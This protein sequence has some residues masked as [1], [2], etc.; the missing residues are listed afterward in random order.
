[1]NSRTSSR[2]LTL[3]FCII[4][5]IFPLF[6][7]NYY[8]N[9]Q[10]SKSLFFIALTCIAFLCMLLCLPRRTFSGENL[11]QYFRQ[12]P[13]L[14]ATLT[15]LLASLYSSI[16]S[17]YGRAAFTG[18]NGRYIGFFLLLSMFISFLLFA[19]HSVD[20]RPYHIFLYVG[21]SLTALIGILQFV[22]ID[23][24][25]LS[26]HVPDL[27]SGMY[28][29]TIGQ[30]NTFSGYASMFSAFCLGAYCLTGKKLLLFPLLVGYTA[31]FVGNS[32]NGFLCLLAVIL[33]L[34]LILNDK[35]P[36]FR[37][38]H[39]LLMLGLSCVL[40]YIIETYG[41]IPYQG[42][43]AVLSRPVIFIPLLLATFLL[44]FIAKTVLTDKNRFIFF[45]RIYLRILVG[46]AVSLLVLV[47]LTNLEA[48]HIFPLLLDDNWGS[49]RGFIW[50]K[51]IE[52]Y[53]DAPL[54]NK[55]FGYGPDTLKPLLLSICK[56]EMLSV[57]GKIYD[58]AHNDFL[59]YLI[60]TG[61]FGA[62]SWLVFWLSVL[63]RSVKTAAR[64]TEIL[65]WLAALIAYLVQTMLIPTQPITA[66]LG[67]MIAGICVGLTHSSSKKI[68]QETAS[69]M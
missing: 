6:F 57:T 66:P 38:L 24:L 37:L 45:K 12:T 65:P 8:Y 56:D 11:Y 33:F 25:G 2:I 62:L 39:G 19:T 51:V 41:L 35:K 69:P 53:K 32:D 60:T 7:T 23:F 40:G 21:G 68:P 30:I 46:L 3:Y 49:F 52:V 1:M 59:Q 14:W 16:F 22:R 5:C 20:L 34:P 63:I 47:L 64:D 26:S 42:I 67:F 50:R 36:I 10:F 13:E 55:L 43:P 44:Y 17:A 54:I 27:L 15:F 61:I 58:S 9:I 18:E 29:S 4:S 31:L 28:L 48:V